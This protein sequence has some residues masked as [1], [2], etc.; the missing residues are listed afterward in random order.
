LTAVASDRH[1][2]PR[3]AA[4]RI[5]VFT[6]THLG[7]HEGVPVREDDSYLGFSEGLSIFRDQKVDLIIHAGDYFHTKF[8]SQAIIDRS[9]TILTD[10]LNSLPPPD[11]KCVTDIPYNKLPFLTIAGNHD[12]FYAATDR[13]ALSSVPGVFLFP[14]APVLDSGKVILNP[15]LLTHNNITVAV[16]GFHYIDEH[17]FNDIQ[18]EFAP[19][20]A[21]F[22]IL[23]L[24]QNSSPATFS[25]L[26]SASGI[27]D[28]VII[29]H[30]HGGDPLIQ[31]KD[32]MII[33]PGS[34]FC[35]AMVEN[36]VMDPNVLILDL[37]ASYSVQIHKLA[38]PMRCFRA[39][40]SDLD[41]IPQLIKKIQRAL[42]FNK[43]RSFLFNAGIEGK[44]DTI[45][46]AKLK[47]FETKCQEI[48]RKPI[49]V[50]D[51]K[52]ESKTTIDL[53]FWTRLREL[54]ELIK[55]VLAQTLP[56]ALNP[57]RWRLKEVP[58][59]S[60]Y[61]FVCCTLSGS[62]IGKPGTAGPAKTEVKLVFESDKETVE[63]TRIFSGTQTECFLAKMA[64]LWMTLDVGSANDFHEIVGT[65][66]FVF[67]FASAPSDVMVLYK[68]GPLKDA[69]FNFFKL[70]SSPNQAITNAHN[71]IKAL[72]KFLDEWVTKQRPETDVAFGK[73]VIKKFANSGAAATEPVESVLDKTLSALTTEMNADSGIAAL[74]EKS[75]ELDQVIGSVN[76]RIVDYW[77]KM[78]FSE[79]TRPLLSAE[80][81][82]KIDESFA[83]ESLGAVERKRV[84][85]V[86]ASLPVR[87]ALIDVMSKDFKLLVLSK[88]YFTA[89]GDVSRFLPIYAHLQVVRI[90]Q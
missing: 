8:P 9:N 73:K 62:K 22:T 23:L 3:D 16:Y 20:T 27:I 79:A 80:F 54:R 74:V 7:A 71:S 75:K 66:Q 42:R 47:E 10:F 57:G 18:F 43:N 77:Q 45:P 50:T 29:G 40:M 26:L 37:G 17:P 24:H 60:L 15:V 51:A 44:R 85:H 48:D 21:N 53:N 76:A 4:M 67:Q 56:F 89:E 13:C 72:Q 11:T 84:A 46:D 33:Q 70:R 63:I 1:L 82:I 69:F 78:E 41:N 61:N 87:A 6:D 28:F 31:K 81:E 38:T 64:G 86:V 5:G 90:P 88:E 58:A 32:P 35:V 49:I 39:A 25:K 12:P 65:P 34:T 14:R 83:P 36:Q 2:T 52:P 19:T 30:Y 68:P 59:N 55:P